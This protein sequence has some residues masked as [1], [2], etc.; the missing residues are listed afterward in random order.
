MVLAQLTPAG[1]ELTER[2][3]VSLS[4]I[5]FSLHGISATAATRVTADLRKVRE[6]LGDLG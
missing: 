1:Q 4:E 3:T 5:G 6:T 2:A